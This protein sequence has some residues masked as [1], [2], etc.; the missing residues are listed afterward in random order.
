MLSKVLGTNEATGKLAQRVFFF[1]SLNSFGEG[2]LSVALDVYR[3]II[4]SQ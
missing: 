1:F 4:A 3:F 2:C